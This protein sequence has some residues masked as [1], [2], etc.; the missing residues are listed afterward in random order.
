MEIQNV[1][2]AKDGGSLMI[3]EKWTSKFCAYLSRRCL[4]PLINEWGIIEA[5]INWHYYM[6]LLN[7]QF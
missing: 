3:G 5:I 4:L 6:A 1:N 2:P 7:T